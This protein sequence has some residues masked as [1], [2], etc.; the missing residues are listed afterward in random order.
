MHIGPGSK[1]DSE[2]LEIMR[3][4][5]QI[6]EQNVLPQ[7]LQPQRFRMCARLQDACSTPTPG[8]K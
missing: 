4:V 7:V 1:T 6:V 2:E 3:Q 8:L 5:T